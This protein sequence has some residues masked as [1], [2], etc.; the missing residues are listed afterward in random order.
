MRTALTK[1]ALDWRAAGAIVTVDGRQIF[2]RRQE[3]AGP[4]LLFLHGFPSSS[5][6][7][8]AVLPLLGERAALTLDFLGFGLSEKPRDSVYSL[9]GQADIVER[10]VDGDA[11][12]VFVVAHDMGTSVATELLARDLERRLSFSVG[13][14][15]L[16][17]GGMIVERTSLTWAQQALRSPL[18]PLVARLSNRPLFVSQFGR[19][20]SEAH[21]LSAA[22]ARD[23]WALWRHAGGAQLAHRLIHYID[24]REA[25]APRWHGAIREWPGRLQF[26]WG[27][28]DPVATPNVL[29]GLRELRPT[30]LVEEL[31]DLGHYP[32][33]EEPA[34]IAALIAE[35]VSAAADPGPTRTRGGG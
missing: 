22:E 8:R 2:E 19:L 20:F 27:M 25:H 32:Q 13:G 21:P 9:F 15:L 1:R 6:D 18:G 24:E 3:G 5:Y 26:A 14:V 16:L 30:A 10:L 35:L 7:W 11:R 33:I 17:N 12:T 31:V 23:Q 29:A 28:R 34:R 4:L